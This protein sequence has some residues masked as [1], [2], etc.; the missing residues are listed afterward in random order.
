MKYVLDCLDICTVSPFQL[1][2]QKCLKIAWPVCTVV[3]TLRP[4]EWIAAK[5]HGPVVCCCDVCG[6][7]VIV[8]VA[9]HV[10]RPPSVGRCP[11]VRAVD[12]LLWAVRPYGTQVHLSNKLLC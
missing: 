9:T 10:Q 12:A 7:F 5:L 4:D 3:F 1:H 2:A 6:C 8:A 11:T